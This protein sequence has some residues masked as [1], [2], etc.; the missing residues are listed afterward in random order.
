MSRRPTPLR[1]GFILA[2]AW[3]ACVALA[4]CQD[5]NLK[6]G[7]DN[8]GHNLDG[9]SGAANDVDTG[10]GTTCPTDA[11]PAVDVP[12][13][14]AC[15]FA[16]GSFTP[17]VEWDV[18]GKQASSLPVVGDLDGDG[19]PEIVVNW[20]FLG[21]GELAAY[22]GDGS[23]LVWETSGA[24]TGFGAHPAMADIDGDGHPEIFIVREYASELYT[25]GSGVYSV[26]EYDWQ[27][28]EVA[29]SDM[30]DDDSFDY[31]TGIS[32]SDMDH[33]GSPE[34]IAG[35]AIFNSD[36]STRGIGQY[37]RGCPAYTGF[38]IYGEG[39]QPAVVDIDLDGKEEVIA[40]DAMYDADGNTVRRIPGGEGAISAG[41]FDSDPEG[42]FVRVSGNTIEAFDTDGSVMWGP[43]TNPS[44][45]I[46]PIPAIGDIDGDGKAE[47]IVSGGNTLWALNAE[48]GSQLWTARVHDMS[49]ATGAA[50]FDFDA[51]GIP[52][53]VYEDEVE[54]VAYN[55]LDGTVKFQTN[56]HASDTMYD[57]PVIA[58]VDADGHAE[59]VVV[60][61]QYSTGMSIYG[62]A[63]NSWAPA[64]KVWNQHD[65][66]ITNINDDL[67]VPVTA[68]PNFTVYN[69]FHSAMNSAPGVA[70]DAELQ[71]E[72][73]SVCTDDCDAGTLRVVARADNTGGSEIPAGLQVA[74]YG[75]TSSGN[76]LLKTADVPDAIASGK[77]S[78]GIELDVATADLV[79]V[80]ALWFVVDDDGTGTGAVAECLEDDNGIAYTGDLCP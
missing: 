14:D 60:H 70:L 23:G 52:E 38:G 29:E 37:G 71:A 39:A 69:S 36:L 55:G 12:L 1:S 40:G 79:G 17:I 67:S 13:N 25:F 6:S 30:F 5:Y 62:D 10:A 61:D 68:V 74:L 2:P 49:G 44:A 54:V 15:H 58:D 28:H 3:V 78:A 24:A 26:V 50:I 18:P 48:D 34:I 53:V 73:V 45:N 43:L 32:V 59:I 56:E 42:E 33:D 4:G 72:I 16:V 8:A 41:N 9:D 57:Y 80:T 46:F 22:H 7:K 64:R 76:V 27:G 66:T 47:I 11:T 21:P 35:R 31:A 20:A 51:D 77:S 19:I 65:Y 75:Q 63:T